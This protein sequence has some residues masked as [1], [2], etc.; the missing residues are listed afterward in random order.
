MQKTKEPHDSEIKNYVRGL[1][2]RS[3][4]VEILWNLE[5]VQDCEGHRYDDAF[6]FAGQCLHIF[7]V[8]FDG[9]HEPHAKGS[10]TCL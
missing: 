4:D 8:F 10:Q 9:E 6:S 1:P 5:R 3:K 7:T 2:Y